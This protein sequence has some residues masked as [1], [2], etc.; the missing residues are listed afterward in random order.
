M[1]F[2]A[3]HSDDEEGDED[4]E[5]QM[6]PMMSPLFPHRHAWKLLISKAANEHANKAL[7][8]WAKEGRGIDW[9]KER[10]PA[11][12]EGM[13]PTPTWNLEAKAAW[14][15]WDLSPAQEYFL[16]AM[17][18]H[19]T[20]LQRH[21]H[22]TRWGSLDYHSLFCPLCYDTCEKVDNSM[23]LLTECQPLQGLREALDQ[24]ASDFMGRVPLHAGTGRKG[25]L[26]A[27]KQM[28]WGDMSPRARMDLLLAH[29][30]PGT[31]PQAC[32]P[33][34]RGMSREEWTKRFVQATLPHAQVLMRERE[35][36]EREAH[37]EPSPDED[38]DSEVPEMEG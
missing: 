19:G 25:G 21:Q 8:E 23:H 26:P 34:T 12:H 4:E 37:P 9:L 14:M 2:E 13:G 7:R 35:R 20:S 3:M 33:G 16:L 28:A 24:A 15:S 1:P 22:Y 27:G 10:P 31:G 11:T 29:T 32:T 36:I 30:P 18:A 38:E 5:V 6:H 17:R